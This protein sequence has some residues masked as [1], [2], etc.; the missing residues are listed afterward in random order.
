VTAAETI[1][2]R[3]DP[4]RKDRLRMAAELSH[5]SLSKF[6][7]DAATARAD[8]VLA[9]QRKTELPAAF[10]DEFFEAI[11]APAPEAL[12]ALA[13]RPRPYRRR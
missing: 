1:N 3:T 2:M 5:V 12:A 8:Q 9:D 7:L 4:E 13:E 6:V 11:N 10:F